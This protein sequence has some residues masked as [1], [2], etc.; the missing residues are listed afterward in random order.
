VPI[1]CSGRLIILHNK[2]SILHAIN[3]RRLCMRMYAHTS[4]TLAGRV[5]LKNFKFK[6]KICVALETEASGQ[7]TYQCN[8]MLKYCNIFIVFSGGLL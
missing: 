7:V 4:L 6:K 8:R 1:R 2:H 3:A 5:S